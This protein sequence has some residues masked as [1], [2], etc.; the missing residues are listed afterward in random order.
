MNKNESFSA[1]VLICC[2]KRCA[3]LN[4]NLKIGKRRLEFDICERPVCL[5]E[6]AV[7]LLFHTATCSAQFTV[8]VHCTVPL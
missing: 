8:C 1:S 5:E 2:L 4:Q 7:S 3:E 6:V